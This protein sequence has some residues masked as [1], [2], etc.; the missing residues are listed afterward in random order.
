[1]KANSL[2]NEQSERTRVVQRLYASIAAHPALLVA[3]M[4]YWTWVNMAFQ[5]P[6]FFP[7]VELDSGW[8]FPSW[9]GPVSLSAVT[10]LVL[11]M[12]FK[13]VNFLFGKRW[14]IGAVAGCMAAGALLC[15]VW[16]NG[17]GASL[18]TPLAC[19]FY[20]AG[21]LGVGLGTACLLLEWGR[22]FGY[23][24]PQ[25][26]LFHGIVAMLASALIVCALAFL[27]TIIGQLL[28]VAI[29]V[30]LAIG[31]YRVM[32]RL[33][34][35]TLLEHGLE[36]ELNVPYKFL[37]TALLH[38]LALGVLLGSAIEQGGSS[39]A[40]LINAL[41]FVVAALLLF[42]SAI[43]VKMD[44]NHLI[45]QVGF[46]IMATG[47]LLIAIVQPFP[48][49]GE[50]FQLVGFCFVHLVMWGLC[51]YLTKNFD[52]PATWVVAWPTCCLMLGQLVGGTATSV[53][54]QQPDSAYW[55]QITAM[56]VCFVMLM[57]AL[58][59]MSNRN[60]TTGWGIARPASAVSTDRA[61]ESVARLLT[62]ENN[63]TPRESE[64]IA[65]LAR[66]RNR[67]FISE[68]LVVSEETIKSHVYSIYRKL[69]IHSQQELLDLVE[70]RAG[71]VRE[72][73]VKPVFESEVP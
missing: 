66:G 5:S 43:F 46:G 27:P 36:A 50:S 12:W 52:L 49:I 6:L 4:L 38:G 11:G 48:A 30:P 55:I 37:V 29:P 21:S 3:L 9:V 2:I 25:E 58:F 44:F 34:K 39:E 16:I 68:E 20:G 14:Y 59:M 41:S 65:L 1:M 73:P 19:A 33:P 28:F 70:V 13:R 69:G 60:L 26:V 61:L 32:R 15:F 54:V 64:I 53:L 23:F 24:G 18:D 40:V 51:S 45:Y 31:F 63:L 47:A 71:T 22:V 8:L 10:Y 35:K 17:Y 7:S 67:K 56:I 62:V 72:D 57:A 42:L